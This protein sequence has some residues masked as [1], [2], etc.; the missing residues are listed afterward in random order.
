MWDTAKKEC[1]VVDV[2]VLLDANLPKIYREMKL[3]HPS[4]IIDAKSVQQLPYIHHSL[5]KNGDATQE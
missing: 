3:K 4:Y 2:A 1:E 5:I